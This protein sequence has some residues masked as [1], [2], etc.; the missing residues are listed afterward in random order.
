MDKQFNSLLD[1]L[2]VFKDEA[3]C[4]KHFEQIRWRNGEYCPHCGHTSIY[5]MTDGKR[6]RCAKCKQDFTI[7]TKT[8]FGESKISLQKWFVAIYLLTQIANSSS[9]SSA[10]AEPMA[11]DSR[12]EKRR[13]K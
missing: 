12:G 9:H 5:R 4:V 7:K 6:Y 11:N 2:A 3:V 10:I 8:I 1:F 13:R